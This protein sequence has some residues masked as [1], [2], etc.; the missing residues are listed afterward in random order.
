MTI[1]LSS[2]DSRS[3]GTKS[4]STLSSGTQTPVEG[5]SAATA[6]SQIKKSK[7]KG[8]GKER[9]PRTGE[10]GET[11]PPSGAGRAE[12]PGQNQEVEEGGGGRTG[13]ASLE[14]PDLSTAQMSSPSRSQ[15]DAP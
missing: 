6:P 12:V 2:L 15:R 14:P 1:L 10:V 3:G 5:L 13:T 9:G 7:E 4:R 11:G 8:K